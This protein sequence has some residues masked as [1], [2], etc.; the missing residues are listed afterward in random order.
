MKSKITALIVD[1]ECYGRN[2][3]KDIVTHYG[4]RAENTF[5][6]IAVP[7]ARCLYSIMGNLIDIDCIVT[8]GDRSMWGELSYMPFMVRK[9]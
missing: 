8:I 4:G 3:Q 9:K 1:S 7:Q 6:I 5:E 2:Y